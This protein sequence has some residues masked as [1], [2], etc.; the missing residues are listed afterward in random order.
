MLRGAVVL[1]S[2]VEL[3]PGQVLLLPRVKDGPVDIVED[4]ERSFPGFAR[5]VM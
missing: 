4:C 1:G 2:L 3:G 5:I